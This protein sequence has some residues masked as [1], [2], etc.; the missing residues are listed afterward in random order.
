MDVFDQARGNIRSALNNFLPKQIN[1][2]SNQKWYQQPTIGNRTS[3]SANQ[4]LSNKVL[5]AQRGFLADNSYD[6][7]MYKKQAQAMADALSNPG[8]GQGSG[9]M[10]SPAGTEWAKVNQWDSL[11]SSAIAKVQR[12]TGIAVPG[13]VVKAVMKLE[14]GGENV[15]CNQ[16]G[17]CGLMQTGSGSW[18]NNFDASYNRTPEGN[19]YY[20]VQEL[21]NWY[22]GIGTSNWTDAAAA[23]FSGYN[24]DN[25]GVSDGYGTTVG[26]YR[27]IIESNLAALNA[28][29]GSSG[30]AGW[31]SG[32]GGRGIQ[33]LF[34]P[35]AD[36]Q[37]DFGV[38]SG[39][40]LYGYGTSYGLNGSQHTGVDVM[41][42]LGSP[43]YAPA[44]GTVVCVGCWR[45]DHFTGGVGR[46]EIEMPDGARVLYDHTNK[47]YV[48]VGQR[49]QG[50]ELI[51]TSGGMYSPHTH[52]EVRIPDSRQSSGYRMVDPVQYFGGYVG[53]GGGGG[54]QV[55][56]QPQQ[57]AYGWD[58]L[59]NMLGGR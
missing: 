51:G 41:Q 17:Y 20:G 6:N 13:N 25:P 57:Q 5:G 50:G 36:S 28:A 18:I 34:G 21:A 48:Q 11:I 43:L 39:N 37:N 31:S 38:T 42:P 45:N 47:S 1:A 35:A 26:Q 9:G 44:G 27:Q 19:I 7:L 32:G 59:R 16:W 46:I 15:G 58:I 56:Q 22:K 33:A 10:G 14:S 53:G 12:E 30:G 2:G 49:L 24:Y 23:Y 54:S 29:G 52:I 4:G 55:T 40:G 8:T 3:G